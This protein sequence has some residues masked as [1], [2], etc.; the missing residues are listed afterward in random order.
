MYAE[1]FGSIGAS[2][3]FSLYAESPGGKTGQPSYC[4]PEV[5]AAIVCSAENPGRVPALPFGVTLLADP[6]L[7]AASART[8][9]AEGKILLEDAFNSIQLLNLKGEGAP[10]GARVAWVG[11]CV[12]DEGPEILF[13]TDL[14]KENYIVYAKRAMAA[15]L[16]H[17]LLSRQVDR[18]RTIIIVAAIVITALAAVA[19]A[20]GTPMR[21]AAVIAIILA[22]LAAYLA[23]E[24]PIIFPYGLYILLMPYDVLL[25]VHGNGTLTKALGEATGLLC[26]FYCLRARYIAPIRQ[27]LI[28]LMLL[29]IWMSVTALWAVDSSDTLQWLP[30]Y[31]GLALLYAALSLTPVSVKDFRIAMGIV[32]VSF[33]VAAVFGIH[34]FYHDPALRETSDIQLQRVSLKLGSSEIDQNHFANAFLF[35]IAILIATLLRT[36]WLTLKAA[37]ALGIGLMVTAILMSGSREAVLAVVIMIAYFLWRGRE[38]MQLLLFTAICAIATAPFTA[39]MAGRFARIFSHTEEGRA[40]IWSVGA[41]AVKHYWLFGSGLGTFPDV[42][43]RFYLA[44]AQLKPDGWT[45]PP[46]DLI[47]HYSVELGIIGMALIVWFW[48][49]H[50]FMLRG[51]ERDH[52][53]Y[54][55][56]V[57]VEAG[58]IGIV[59]VS[60]FIDLFTYKYA[61]LALAS[62]AQVAYLGTTMRRVAASGREREEPA[63]TPQLASPPA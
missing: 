53:L 9:A 38:R 49:S 17:K 37:C 40:A 20:G 29:L 46:H 28:V 5:L 55:D 58:L 63:A 25:V 14:A 61:W 52:P 50:F 62:V 36:R 26:F 48:A 1:L 24:H 10:K 54:D 3:M 41:A 31:F 13:L 23:L 57:M 7:H 16:A 43:D 21:I 42:Y 51:I 4:G 8:N 32:A 12:W 47:L 39:L 2:A 60:F 45:R 33:I 27:P 56:R 6:P 18:Q 34:T 44:V 22:P 59:V 11:P 35:P 19:L 15:L 30:T